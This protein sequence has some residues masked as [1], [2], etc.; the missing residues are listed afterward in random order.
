MRLAWTG[1][2]SSGPIAPGNAAL[3]EFSVARTVSAILATGRRVVL[4]GPIPEVGRD[5]PNSLARAALF[6]RIPEPFLT[7][8]AYKAR[9]A[10]T[11]ALLTR[12]AEA[13]DRVTY[14][15]LSDLFCDT[16]FCRVTS[17]DGISFYVDSNHI[18]QTAARTLLP[19][20]LSEIWQGR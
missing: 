5:V 1:D 2:P 6:G 20:R 17:E 13:D 12:V 7:T 19:P 16:Q 14:I 4:L 3:V 11:E 10:R 8:D 15:P 9:A 18:S